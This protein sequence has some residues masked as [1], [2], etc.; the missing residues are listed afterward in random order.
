M[1]LIIYTNVAD[2][3]SDKF[4]MDVEAEFFDI[5]FMNDSYT[6]DI[7]SYVEMGRVQDGEIFID[8]FDRPLFRRFVSTGTK[9]SLLVMYEKD[10]IINSTE[11]GRNA[12][13]AIIAYATSGAIYRPAGSFELEKIKDDI[14]VIF[15][16]TRYTKFDEL[17]RDLGEC[18]LTV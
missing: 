18:L 2:V 17:R 3:P 15:N 7:L 1:S 11:L 6:E 5:R 8:R 14:D 10:K 12:V 16:E 4:V 9:G 13:S